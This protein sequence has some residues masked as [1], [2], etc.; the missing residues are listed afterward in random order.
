MAEEIPR[1]AAEEML[2]ENK[3]EDDGRTDEER[4]GGNI[5]LINFKLES[6]E[7]KVVKKIVGDY[8][9]KI[10]EKFNYQELKLRLKKKQHGKAFL[11]EIDAEL[12]LLESGKT[13]R[14]VT[15]VS[16]YNLFSCVA[17]TMK[18]L[19]S[20]AEHEVKKEKKGIMKER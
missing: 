3:Q 9:R 8:V 2:K 15:N 13:S 14:A 17:E 4:L 20:E 18:K 10:Q 19:I 11:Y 7:L 5:A 16:D 6:A 12:Y 1:G